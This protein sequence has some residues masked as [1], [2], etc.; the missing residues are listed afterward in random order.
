MGHR[1]QFYLKLLNLIKVIELTVVQASGIT[2]EWFKPFPTLHYNSPGMT[3]ISFC[4]VRNRMYVN[5]S[6]GSS[7]LIVI[8]DVAISCCT[9]PA[10]RTETASSMLDLIG[11]P[12]KYFTKKY[13][14]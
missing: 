2:F 9:N 8:C 6:V 11:M 10:Y 3:M 13:K 14:F 1:T 5:L 12:E 4:L 7:F